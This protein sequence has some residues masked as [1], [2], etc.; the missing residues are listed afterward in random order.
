MRLLM[1]LLAPSVCA[2]PGLAQ[3]LD[4]RLSP[5]QL[6]PTTFSEITAVRELSDGRLLLLDAHDQ[7]LQ[8]VD[9][10]SSSVRAVG[11]I[12][13]GPGEYRRATELLVAGGDATL[14][15]DAG[16]RRLLVIA[17]DG[18]SPGVVLRNEP[19]QWLPIASDRQGHAYGIG[20]IADLAKDV[21]RLP[22]S[23][24]LMRLDLASGKVTR[25]AIVAAPPSEVHV[26]KNGQKIE[27]VDVVRPPFT[28]GYQFAV[29][30][31][32]RL[33]IAAHLSNASSRGRLT[34]LGCRRAGCGRSLRS[35]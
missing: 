23:L 11:R 17:A 35:R 28:V 9:L 20:P 13:S 7:T 14:V 8:L 5:P 1:Y 18:T 19:G 15:A 16:T 27:S 10:A 2:S 30:S 34:V 4:R 21:S 24:A 26:K 29:A 33:A 6:F 22:D 3:A 12:G 25:L 32:G 31:D